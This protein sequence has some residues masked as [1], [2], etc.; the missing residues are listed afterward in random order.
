LPIAVSNLALDL[1]GVK[2]IDSNALIHLKSVYFKI[3][4]NL[5]EIKIINFKDKFK[6]M[7]S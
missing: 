1:K 3:K 7:V 5:N 4:E 6:K 2:S